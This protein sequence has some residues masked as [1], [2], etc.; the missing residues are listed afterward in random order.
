MTSEIDPFNKII[1][2]INSKGERFM[3]KYDPER[4]GKSENSQVDSEGRKLIMDNKM[5]RLGFPEEV[6][7]ITINYISVRN[8]FQHS[9]SDIKP[10]HLDLAREVFVQVFVDLILNGL[11]PKLLVNNREQFNSGLQAFFSKRLT[12]NPRFRKKIV[13][14]IKTIF[15][16]FRLDF[17][18]IFFIYNIVVYVYLWKKN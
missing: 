16:K 3:E 8:N 4:F 15:S 17:F 5:G 9:M 7:T 1:R 6:E 11:E 12:G 10:S 13:T 2:L 14:R 18:Y